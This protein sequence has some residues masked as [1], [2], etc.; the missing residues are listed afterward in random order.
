MRTVKLDPSG[1]KNLLDFA[2]AVNSSVSFSHFSS[3]TPFR[4]DL[5]AGVFAYTDLHSE[6]QDVTRRKLR[7][8]AALFPD[9]RLREL[10]SILHGVVDNRQLS[11]QDVR[12][13]LE[14]RSL[15]NPQ[16]KMRETPV[17]TIQAVGRL[18]MQGYQYVAVAKMLRVSVD[19]VKRIDYYCGI[20]EARDNALLDA[21]ILAVG[22]GESVRK[23][24]TRKGLPNSTSHRLLQKARAVLVELGEVV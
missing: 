2:D 9:T 10:A 16:L 18:L 19:T 7:Y 17:E 21:A 23:F 14:G 22:D 5:R 20:V 13:I 12:L 8:L 1:L 15:S 11:L 6:P 3:D 4:E 24:A